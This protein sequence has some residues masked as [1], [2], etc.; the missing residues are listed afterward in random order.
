MDFSLETHNC[1]VGKNCKQSVSL[2][3]GTLRELANSLSLKLGDNHLGHISHVF[4]FEMLE[5]GCSD[6][7]L[8]LRSIIAGTRLSEKKPRTHVSSCQP[9]KQTPASHLDSLNLY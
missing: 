4:N 7:I 2:V 9:F 8:R 6:L 1:A 3:D 5:E